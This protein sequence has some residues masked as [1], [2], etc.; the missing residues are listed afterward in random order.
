[1][2]DIKIL[3]V[4]PARNEAA[5]LQFLLNSLS[6]QD[7]KVVSLFVLVDDDSTD[8]TSEILKGMN[9]SY[10]HKSIKVKS[11]GRIITGAAFYAWW[12]GVNFAL[13]SGEK[14]DYVMKLD[15]DVI[16]A[17]D[18]FSSLKPGFFEQDDVLGGVIQGFS[19]EQK[20]YIPGPVKLYS[21]RALDLL[22]TLPVATGFDVMDEIICSINGYK[23]SVYPEAKFELNRPIGF[24]QGKLHGRY[25][26]GLVCKWTGYAPEYFLLH[27]LRYIFRKPYIIGSVWMLVGFIFAGNGPY[28]QELRLAHRRMQRRRLI[29]LA[30]NPIK[31]LIE[32]YR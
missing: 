30:R 1:M 20:T 23:I 12:E 21:M 16:L 8:G 13:T 28:Q 17:P 26:N 18:Y 25:R 9:P 32:N 6:D 10:R 7:M 3:V 15:A 29:V 4:T 27:F 14:F 19:R 5:N 31:F 22:R 2:I 11:S 24:S